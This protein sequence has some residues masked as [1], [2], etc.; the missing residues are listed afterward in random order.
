[1]VA[2]GRLALSHAQLAAFCNFHGRSGKIHTLVT[3]NRRY[4]SRQQGEVG[5]RSSPPKPANVKLWRSMMTQPTRST[6]LKAGLATHPRNCRYSSTRWFT[7]LQNRG[8]RK[9]ECPREREKLADEAQERWLHLFGGDLSR[10]FEINPF[11][12]LAMT[13]CY[14]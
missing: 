11:T 13:T 4:W 12:R 14:Y 3:A 6:C 8:K 2:S 7:T 9:F 10:H 5:L 1:M